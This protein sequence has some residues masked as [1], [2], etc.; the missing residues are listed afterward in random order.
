MLSS[1]SA[2][3]LIYLLIGAI[4]SLILAVRGRGWRPRFFIVSQLVAWT[5]GGWVVMLWIAMLEKPESPS[6]RQDGALVRDPDDD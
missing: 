5:G 3:L 4:P 1:W 6:L 2:F